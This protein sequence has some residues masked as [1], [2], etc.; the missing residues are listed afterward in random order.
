MKR[1]A[2]AFLVAPFPAAFIQSVVVAL[3]PKQSMDV[4]AHPLSMFVAICLLFYL[5][6]LV[7]ALPLYLAV[8]KRLPRRMA[9]YGLAGTLIALLPIIA[10]VGAS[11]ARGGM[12]T[13]AVLYNL[14]FFAVGGLLAGALFWL[15]TRPDRAEPMSASIFS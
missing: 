10:A 3:W 11:V 9:I 7:F 1:V 15:V 13:Y 14:A 12:S 5:V 8:R 6:E 2:L 4:F